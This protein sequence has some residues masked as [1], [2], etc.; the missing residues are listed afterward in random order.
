[1]TIEGPAITRIALEM[2]AEIGRRTRLPVQGF[3][4]WP[5]LRSGELVSVRHGG[6]LPEIGQI[7]VFLDGQK[8][9][10]HR[11][12]QRRLAGR[13]ILFRT[14]GDTCLTADRAWASPDSMV[15]VVEGIVA[16]DVIV[17]RFAMG[18]RWGR[19]LAVLSRV[20]GLLCTPLQF[21]RVRGS[22]R[23]SSRRPPGVSR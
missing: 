3:S 10:A 2:W 7:I 11:V 18:G 21:I 5:V 9:V 19:F 15:G 6:A 22:I 16:R 12:I 20:Q 8:A 1:V 13:Q 4:M 23:R 14:K 17:K